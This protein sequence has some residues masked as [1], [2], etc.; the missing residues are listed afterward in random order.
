MLSRTRFKERLWTRKGRPFAFLGPLLTPLT[1][2]AKEKRR[3]AWS[4]A[5]GIVAAGCAAA[6]IEWQAHDLENQAR[7]LVAKY[8]AVPLP[9]SRNAKG[10]TE[11]VEKICDPADFTPADPSFQFTGDLKEIADKRESAKTIRETTAFWTGVIFGVFGIPLVWYFLLDRIREISGA[12]SGRDQQTL[13]RST[14][15]GCRR[16][17]RLARCR[18]RRVASIP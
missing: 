18:Q 4:L 11:K 15:A 10:E 17:R 6:W 3:A 12:I 7:V 2:L 8:E 5:I 1:M 16:H 9:V 13:N 14:T